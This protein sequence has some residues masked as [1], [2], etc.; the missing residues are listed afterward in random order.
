MNRWLCLMALALVVACD[1]GGGGPGGSST[2]DQGGETPTDARRPRD[3]TGEPGAEVGNVGDRGGPVDG[4]GPVDAVHLADAAHPADA[5]TDARPPVDAAP[6]PDAGP[7]LSA[8]ALAARDDLRALHAASAVPVEIRFRDGVPVTLRLD[9][10]VPPGGDDFERAVAFLSTYD[11][12]F[13]LL[14][15]EERLTPLYSQGDDVHR[16]VTLAVTLHGQPLFGGAITLRLDGERLTA[17]QANYTR[18]I[19]EAAEPALAAPEARRLATVSLAGIDVNGDHRPTPQC[20]AEVQMPG[21]VAALP[22]VLVWFAPEM[23][24]LTGAPRLAWAFALRGAPDGTARRLVDALDGRVLLD[25]PEAA[26]HQGAHGEIQLRVDGG[27]CTTTGCDDRFRETYATVLVGVLTQDEQDAVR[28]VSIASP[29]GTDTN[30][31]DFR[32]VSQALADTYTWF[33]DRLGR[34]GWDDVAPEVCVDLEEFEWNGR[35]IALP[36]PINVCQA[37]ARDRVRTRAAVR[38]RQTPPPDDDPL[39]ECPSWLNARYMAPC[40]ELQFGDGVTSQ[41]IVTHEFTHGHIHHARVLGLSFVNESG[42]VHEALSDVLACARTRD[43]LVGEGTPIATCLSSQNDAAGNAIRVTRDLS[44]PRNGVAGGCNFPDHMWAALSSDGRGFVPPDGLPALGNDF[45]Q[46]HGNSTILSHAFYLLARGGR[47]PLSGIEVARGVGDECVAR[48][49]NRVIVER[50]DF[51]SGFLQVAAAA[52]DAAGDLGGQEGCPPRDD[53]VCMA[54]NAFAAVGLA[55]ADVDC[56]GTPEALDV[57]DDGDGILDADDNC[58][59][60][61]NTLQENSDP[62]AQ[63][64]ACDTDDDDDGVL[65]GNDNCPTTPNANQNDRNGNRIGNACDDPDAD[66]VVDARDNCWND[67]NPGQENFDRDANGDACDPDDD[68]DRID[69][70]VDLCPFRVGGAPGEDRDGDRVGDVCDNCPDVANPTQENGDAFADALGDACDPDADG[71]GVPERP[72]DGGPPDNCPAAFNP[73]QIDADGDGLGLACDPGDLVFARPAPQGPF[74]FRARLRPIVPPQA[75]RMPL[76]V[77]E[78]LD[79]APLLNA[80]GGRFGLHV[81]LPLWAAL[82]VVDETGRTVAGSAAKPE[83]MIGVELPRD[84]LTLG[85]GGAPAPRHFFYL[86]IALPP[87]AEAP[88]D[89]E[90]QIEILPEPVDL[91]PRIT[92]APERLVL[93][94]GRTVPLTATAF[95]PNGDDLNLFWRVAEGDGTLDGIGGFENVYRAVDSALGS[96]H[97]VEVMALTATAVR[98]ATV[99]LV[100]QGWPDFGNGDIPELDCT[101][102]EDTNGNSLRGCADP[103]CV[104]RPCVTGDPCRE[105]GRCMDDGVCFAATLDCDDEDACTRDVC[106]AGACL[107]PEVRFCCQGPGCPVDALRIEAPR[108]GDHVAAPGTVEVRVEIEGRLPAR[109]TLRRNDEPVL[110]DGAPPFRFRV[111]IPAGAAGVQTLTARAEYDDGTRS[112]EVSVSVFADAVATM[113][114]A[115]RVVDHMGAPVPDAT[116]FVIGAL[117][118]TATDGFGEFRLNGLRADGP[119]ELGVLATVAGEVR[120]QAFGPFPP[121]PND[122]DDVGDLALVRPVQPLRDVVGAVVAPPVGFRVIAGLTADTQPAGPIVAPPVGFRVIAGLTADTQPA[123]PVVAPPVG[124]STLPRV[125]A[126]D[127]AQVAVTPGDVELTLT[128]VGLD[129]VG[130]VSV[131]GAGGPPADFIDVIDYAPTPDGR[132]ARLALSLRETLGYEARY[133]LELHSARGTT[134]ADP[135]DPRASFACTPP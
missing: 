10:P 58:P 26:T 79:C 123:G 57:D 18:E 39:P 95:D 61:P 64:D 101:A 50:L 66:G 81:R 28:D 20:A 107:H 45:G 97:R 5:A 88:L 83:H 111:P 82:R 33:H 16:T 96:S 68:N 62:D 40:E 120:Y 102:D 104:G 51:L 114:V 11:G 135:Q 98:G 1:G 4:S 117:D 128:G 23:V 48:V 27:Q 67:A 46:V 87:A 130:A 7:P 133:G 12:L 6:L 69:D 121:A 55:N 115:G 127:P 110:V 94:V 108:A 36:S 103:T 22:P 116:V 112:G 125:H 14:E 3:G 76:A 25:L 52:I 21:A 93:P 119:Y 113:D 34:H 89:G 38:V 91:P 54:R 100:F 24:G 75:L 35:T 19:P 134:A 118:L 74:E 131:L 78:A 70:L 56:D 86:E 41:D 30:D 32:A 37:N 43:W 122:F 17:V 106:E 71:D 9:V 42:A 65:D 72:V 126:V 15:P 2:P 8:E 44:R 13:G 53:L 105:E 85:P 73:D 109:V 84:F 80:R 92:V 47:H 49:A 124:F 63:G 77:C 129:A 90:V 31:A 29:P 99:E 132:S 60:V 59:L